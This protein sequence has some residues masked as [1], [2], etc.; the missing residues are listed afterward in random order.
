N[1]TAVLH[2]QALVV[3]ANPQT[4]TATV[5]NPNQVDP[6]PGNNTDTSPVTPQQADLVV[7]KAVDNAT[8]NLR[9]LVHFLVPVRNARPNQATGVSIQD[10]L[11]AGLTFDS[12][13]AS[14]GGYDSGTGTWMVGTLDI[15]S[16]AVLEIAARVTAPGLHINTADISHSD[17][18]DPNTV[19]N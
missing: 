1:G 17:Q 5:S 18:F 10:Q 15:K 19:N 11:R 7:T 14:Q 8:P 4:N 6:N 2:I 3:D 12:F 13:N 16:A 9:D